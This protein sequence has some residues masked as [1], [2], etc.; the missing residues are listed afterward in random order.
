MRAEFER[1]IAGKL[2]DNW[3][4]AVAALKQEIAD[5]KP[6]IA[7]RAVQPEGAGGAGAGD[8][9]TDR[10]LGRPDRLQ[11]DLC[12]VAWAR[13]MPGNFSGRYIHYG[14]REHGMAPRPTAWRCMA[15]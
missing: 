13:C 5:T 8:A 9:G 14:V 7:T 4:E 3:H 10:R 1:V 12:E 6:K 11:P 2:P 15:A